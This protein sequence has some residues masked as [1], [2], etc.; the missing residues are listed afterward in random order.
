MAQC[1]IF[2]HMASERDLQVDKII[3]DAKVEKDPMADS[4]LPAQAKPMPSRGRALAFADCDV[5]SVISLK[6]ASFV[7]PE[8]ERVEERAVRVVTTP[9]TSTG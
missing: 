1:P 3:F 6:M 7:T 2:S 9:Q 5:P 4:G 8:G